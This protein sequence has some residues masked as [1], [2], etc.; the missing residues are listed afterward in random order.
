[1]VDRTKPPLRQIA[2]DDITITVD[3]V[4]YHPHAGE[5]AWFRPGASS[6]AMRILMDIQ[7]L[8]KPDL[9]TDEAAEFGQLLQDAAAYVAIAVVKWDWTDIDEQPMP[10]PTAE[11]ALNLDIQELTWLLQ[12]SVTGLSEAASKN[13]VS[14]ST[15]T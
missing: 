7:S 4:E 6:N 3:G 5:S 13:A 15:S 11:S 2:S 10:Q 12:A 1:M 9:S 8:Q 14:P